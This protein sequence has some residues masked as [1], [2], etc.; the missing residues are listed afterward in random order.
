MHKIFSKKMKLLVQCFLFTLLIFA[1]CCS[2][3]FYQGPIDAQAAYNGTLKIK[4]NHLTEDETAKPDFDAWRTMSSWWDGYVDCS[5]QFDLLYY[6]NYGSDGGIGFVLSNSY[7]ADAVRNNAVQYGYILDGSS[8][9]YQTSPDESASGEVID[10]ESSV[11]GGMTVRAEFRN[12]T[13]FTLKAKK[14]GSSNFRVLFTS[15]EHAGAPSGYKDGAFISLLFSGAVEAEIDNLIMSKQSGETEIVDEGTSFDSTDLAAMIPTA[16]TA[17]ESA[18]S[19]TVVTGDPLRIS[20][21]DA[22]LG[23]QQVW[24]GGA[25]Y[26]AFWETS[27]KILRANNALKIH[28]PE[29]EGYFTNGY[30][31]RSVRLT[32]ENGEYQTSRAGTVIEVDILD[33][34]DNSNWSYINF[35]T[36]VGDILA[37]TAGADMLNSSSGYWTSSPGGLP[38]RDPGWGWQIQPS[39]GM[40]LKI[41]YDVDTATIGTDQVTGDIR[42]YGAEIPQ[43]GQEPAYSLL[44]TEEKFNDVS[45]NWITG[46]AWN[47]GED[48]SGGYAGIY[49]NTPREVIVDNLKISGFLGENEEDGLR[50][51]YFETFDAPL[52]AIPDDTSASIR[53]G[54]L[55]LSGYTATGDASS[56]SRTGRLFS[57]IDRNDRSIVYHTNGGQNTTNLS[58]YGDE[59]YVLQ[60]AAKQGYDFGGWYI[61]PDFTEGGKVESISGQAVGPKELYAQWNL[62]EYTISY[63]GTEDAE[64]TNPTAY[65]IEN[66]EIVLAALVREGFEFGGWYSDEGLQQKAETIPT[67]SYGNKTFY[68]KWLQIYTITYENLHGAEHS[69]PTQFTQ[70]SETIVFSAPTLAGYAFDGWYAEPEYITPVTEIKTGTTGDQTLYAKWNKK[71]LITYENTKGA[72]NSNPVD[73]FTGDPEIVLVGLSKEGY[74]FLGWYDGES[75]DAQRVEKIQTTESDVVVYAKWSLIEYKITYNGTEDAENNNPTTYTVE[76]EEIILQPLEREGYRFNGWFDTQGK[77]VTSIPAGSTGDI[78]LTA[79]FEKEYTVR[80]EGTMDAPNPNPTSFFLSDG[81]K[82]LLNL[83]QTGYTFDGWFADQEYQNRVTSIGIAEGDLTLYAKWTPITYTITYVNVSDAANSNPGT[84][85]IGGA[86]VLQPLSREGYDFG[87][88]YT[89]EALT[90]QITEIA[91]GTTGNVTVYAKWT[92]KTFTV[93]FDFCCDINSQQQTVSYGGVIQQPEVPARDGYTFAGWYTDSSYSTAWDFANG[94]V[95]DSMTLYAKWEQNSSGA[96]SCSSTMSGGALSV[97]VA[98]IAA[99]AAVLIKK[100]GKKC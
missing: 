47:A 70:E 40:R 20:V 83:S 92:L 27:E 12:K 3:A 48:F 18:A 85:T 41:V 26:T 38:G 75:D 65:T 90:Q 42:L 29:N 45:M 91:A 94:T 39:R 59:G 1:V 11:G 57:V 5:I 2:V 99:V 100:S 15:S 54:N 73:F 19:M 60:P 67:G 56:V 55:I 33:F 97:A 23:A 43:N 36:G 52:S 84:Y 51:I 24:P 68:A 32:G 77:E 53:Y 7:A 14:I 21:Y 50:E 28:F 81:E 74:N 46:G 9:S 49:F 35:F 76:S 10:L 6:H 80:Y 13:D 95:S 4:P 17:G 96:G 79:Q 30:N 71:N 44:Q 25:D 61:T 78:E 34:N 87:G 62:T 66:E 98:A 89:D 82:P 64:N 37:D 58:E 16:H 31:I 88:W 8:L 22:T 63:I 86:I 69:N 72:E 93:T